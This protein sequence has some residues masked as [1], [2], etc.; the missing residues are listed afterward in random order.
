MSNDVFLKSNFSNKQFIITTGITKEF[1]E[2]T[3]NWF[4]SLKRINLHQNVLVVCFDKYTYKELKDNDIPFIFIETEITID[5]IEDDITIKKRFEILKYLIETLKVDLIYSDVDIVFFKNPIEKILK[6]KTN[7]DL[8][9][10][11]NY[12]VNLF[13]KRYGWGDQK[14]KNDITCNNLSFNFFYI[15]YKGIKTI[16]FW[17]DILKNIINIRH[18]REQFKTL[19]SINNFFGI[20]IHLLSNIEFC[21]FSCVFNNFYKNYYFDNC[22]LL[23]Y[24]YRHYIEYFNPFGKSFKDFN[25]LN[26]VKNDK[27]KLMKMNNHWYI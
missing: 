19:N 4:E 15:P 24:N 3:L 17:E 14:I 27:I 20:N 5:T 9:L 25:Q 6:L 1:V 8:I 2:M 13:I 23:H 11:V 16:K 12:P 10:S 7:N 26:M 18:I 22:Y 21:N